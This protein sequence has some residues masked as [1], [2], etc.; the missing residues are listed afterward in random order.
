MRVVRVIARLNIGGPAIQVISLTKLL[1][2]LGYETVLVRGVEGP[3]EGSMD[4]LASEMDVHPQLLSSLRRELGPH[5]VR[6]VAELVRLFRRVRPTILH[7]H[8]AKAGTVGRI[9]ALLAGQSAPPVRV[10]TFHG[11]V[12]KGEFASPRTAGAF[13]RIERALAR[14][15]SRLVAV[16]EEVRHDLVRLR[17]APPEKI[18][19]V[20]LGFDLAPFAATPEVRAAN[21]A[22]VRWQ[23]DIPAEAKVVSVIARVVRVKRIDRFIE[24]ARSLKD[25]ADA[26]FVVVGDGDLRESLE[27][28]E[29][30]R[31]LG[32]RLVW[33]GFRH[34]IAAVCHA[35]DVVALTSA[36][37]GTPVC[38]IEGQAAGVPVVANDVGGVRTV[39]H[40]GSTGFV[41]PEAD[42]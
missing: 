37:E 9:A 42:P 34:D 23:L 28:S 14:S 13:A 31:S 20:H 41:I 38:L 2:P 4:H 39:V 24:L 21:R 12:F 10:H 25:E 35:S 8:T 33:A 18:E 19:V 15:T 22:A 5:D 27:Q 1:E 32:N 40:D 11:H 6:S 7:T 29:I 26:Y 3:H 16:S 30:A 36:N 17:I